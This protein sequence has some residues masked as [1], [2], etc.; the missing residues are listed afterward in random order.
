MHNVVYVFQCISVNCYLFF[1]HLPS[2]TIWQ[3]AQDHTLLIVFQI[4]LLTVRYAWSVVSIALSSTNM[5]T[6]NCLSEYRLCRGKTRFYLGHFLVTLRLICAV[7]QLSLLPAWL[8]TDV[9]VEIDK[10]IPNVQQLIA[11]KHK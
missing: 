8:E 2:L 6:L 7:D 3:T 1:F 9:Q 4:R 5:A 11:Y 10:W